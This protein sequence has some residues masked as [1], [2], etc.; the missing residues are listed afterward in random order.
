MHTLIIGLDAFDPGAFERLAAGGLLPNLTAFAEAGQYAHLAIANPAQSE[1]S[2]TSIA[3]GANP[4]GHGLFDFVHRDPASYTPYVS[5]LPTR[6]NRLGARFVPPHRSTTVFDQAAADGYPATALFWPAS[7]PARHDSPVRVIPGLGTPDLQGRL[8]VA[9]AF[10]LEGSSGQ[11]DLKTRIERLQPVGRERYRGVLPGPH[12]RGNGRPPRGLEFELALSGERSAVL[13]WGNEATELAVG[14]WSPIIELSFRAGGILPVKAI[15]RAILTQGK[16]APRLYFLPLQ[17]HPLRALW[18]YGSPPGFLREIWQ[19]AGP[20]L[21]L[22]WPQD[23][24]GLEEG[25]IDDEQFL[26]LCRLIDAER[27]R[28]FFQ[29]L[30]NFTEGVLGVVFDTLDRVQH[31]FWRDRPDVVAEWYHHLDEVVGRAVAQLHRLGGEPARVLVVSDHGFARFDHQVHLNGWLE[32]H[33]YLIRKNPQGSRSLANIDWA[34]SRAY[35]IGLNSIYLNLSGREGQG[36]VAPGEAE[37]LAERLRFELSAWRGP[38]GAPV[39]QRVYTRAEALDGPLAAHG[40]DLL[41]GYSP[42]YRASAETGVGEWSERAIE[43]NRDHWGADH[44]IDPLAV[45]GVLFA[46]QGLDNLPHPSYRDIPALALDRPIDPQQ[47]PPPPPDAG[48]PDHAEDPEA[49]AERLKSLGYL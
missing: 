49:V 21:T 28:V 20:Y 29:Q 25:W 5:L 24:T 6:G 46:N 22:G 33:G 40:P 27:E 2:W 1:V 19:Q 31:M 34:R 10:T 42:G 9:T 39:V 18:P 16:P 38:D 43:P 37:S 13:Q 41:I 15:T 45:P 35:A 11:T 3:T 44:C 8:G 7:F 30:W 14:L 4:G 48:T 17:I 26:T 12:A 36:C 47:A 23:T 32:A